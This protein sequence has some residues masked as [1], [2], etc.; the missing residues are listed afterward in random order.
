MG[1]NHEK[2][3]SENEKEEMEQ[4]QIRVPIDVPK[5]DEKEKPKEEVQLDRPDQGSVELQFGVNTQRKEIKPVLHV[6]LYPVLV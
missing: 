1:D 2:A 5:R 4:P 6:F 3:K